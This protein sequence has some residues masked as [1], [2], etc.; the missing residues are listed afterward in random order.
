M[1]EGKKPP[2][3]VLGWWWMYGEVKWLGGKPA[4]LMGAGKVSMLV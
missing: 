4:E 2:Q 1:S 3:T